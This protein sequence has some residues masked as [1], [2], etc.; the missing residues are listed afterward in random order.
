MSDDVDVATAQPAQQQPGPGQR[1]RAAREKAGLDPARIAAQLHINVDQVAALEADRYEAFAARVFVRGYLRNYARL[2]SLPVDDILG[3]FDA[4]WPEGQGAAPLRS[5]GTHKPQVGSGHGV[6]RTVTWVLLIGLIAL[7][8]AWWSGYLQDH[9]A[10]LQAPLDEVS[11]P[12]ANDDGAAIS[13]PDGSLLLPAP[14][15]VTAPVAAD[16]P[17]AP[18]VDAAAP[19]GLEATPVESSAPT[20]EP[21]VDTPPVT[22][23]E[24][25]VS[26]PQVVLSLTGPCWVSI[27]DS[28]GNYRLSGLYKAG[29]REVLGGEPPYRVQLGD[30]SVATLTV[31]G[32]PV[33]LTAHRRGKVA[34][35]TL[36]PGAQ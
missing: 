23:A 31:D 10:T 27:S 12:D 32:Q 3:G 30:A 9:G 22:E 18:V 26:G 36:D 1:L 19:D 4:A 34:R 20:A 24:P 14:P 17:D 21:E 15:V 7:F 28:G 2:V 35:F 5:V 6:V 33:D 8:F 25:V 13:G 29:F 11:P 16:T